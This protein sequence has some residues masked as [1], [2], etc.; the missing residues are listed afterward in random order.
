MQDSYTYFFSSWEELFSSP[1]GVALAGVGL[2]IAL[3]FLAAVLV[4]YIFQSCSLYSIAKRRGISNPGLAWVPVAFVWI[5]GSVSD[6]YQYVVRGKVCNRRKILLALGLACFL[7]SGG[8]LV[9]LSNYGAVLDAFQGS[10][11]FLRQVLGRAAGGTLAGLAAAALAVFQYISLYDVF[12][13]CNPGTSVV[14]LVLSVIFPI[15]V[16][17]FLFADRKKELGMPR[18]R[19]AP[20]S[21]PEQGAEEEAH[22]DPRHYVDRD[23]PVDF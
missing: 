2:I 1:V 5:L 9:F 7:L 16:P 17:F 21:A 4:L 14:F 23:H 22:T 11:T 6:Q 20:A 19:D 10:G 12:Q 13:S 8:G 18:R 3:F 15:L